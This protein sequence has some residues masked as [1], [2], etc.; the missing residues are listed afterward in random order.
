MW[1]GKL[2]NFRNIELCCKKVGDAKNIAMSKKVEKNFK[3][4]EIG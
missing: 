1:E 4:V 3:S 2:L